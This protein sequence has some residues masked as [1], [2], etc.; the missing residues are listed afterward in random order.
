MKN[1]Y[2]TSR[3]FSFYLYR[4]SLLLILSTFVHSEFFPINANEESKQ[5]VKENLIIGFSHRTFLDVNPTDAKAS[6]KVLAYTFGKEAGFDL[7]IESI[8]YD[9]LEQY[10]ID[11]L[12]N[13][14]QL[15]IMD[16]W[17]M[18]QMGIEDQLPLS[19]VSKEDSESAEEFL[20]EEY[21][22]LVHKD[23]SIN[24]LQDLKNRSVLVLETTN[25]NL[26]LPWITCLLLENQLSSPDRFFS[27]YQFVRNPMNTVLPIFFQKEDACIVDR[28]SFQILSELNPQINQSL[29][30]LSRSKPLVNTVISVSKGGNWSNEDNR[31]ILIKILRDLHLSI[32]GKQILDLFGVSR[33]IPFEEK[34][35]QNV[36]E[37]K[38]TYDQLAGKQ[39]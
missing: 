22:L 39:N 32:E 6:L 7:D 36:R 11:I 31:D 19:F 1:V 24:R 26:S 30:I 4:F 28:S 25:T 37:L 20:G 9:N 35:L 12:G 29:K 2:I 10:K 27:K 16:T 14:I 18:F 21:V 17:E 13:K 33:F 23:K 8:I 38:N 15:I 3:L 34:H 5:L